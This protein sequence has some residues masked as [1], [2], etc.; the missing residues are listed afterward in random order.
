MSETVG[1]KTFLSKS[2]GIGGAIKEK[3]EDFL[4]E[5]ITPE[6]IVLEL[7]KNQKFENEEGEYTHFTLEKTNWDTIR[8]VKNVAKRCGV[9][10]KRLKYAGTKDRRSI[11]AQRVS[12]WKVPAEKLEKINI[13]DIALRDFSTAKDPIN[14]GTL[15]GN[16]FSILIKK[17]PDDADNRLEKIVSELKNRAPNFFGTQR[18]G[19][20]MNNHIIGKHILR[21]EFEEAVMAYLCDTGNEPDEATKE[22]EKLREGKDF[23]RAFKH[24]PDYLGYEK[25]ILNRLMKEPTDF[26]GSLRELPKKLRWMFV[27]AYQ[28]YIFNLALCDY[29]ESGEIPEEIPL[30]GTETPPDKVSDKILKREKNSQKDFTVPSM[31]EM[32]STGNMRKSVISFKDF[33]I[34][35]FNREKHKIW[36]RFGLPPGAY[37]TIVLRELMK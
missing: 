17:V 37:A 28:G 19:S 26:I 8:A 29:I 13:K 5:E 24:F 2:E 1:L 16:R 9:S 33:E 25:A 14:L 3:P 10:H 20:R 23:S 31:P 6:G 32:T 36:V 21:G 15:K 35:D 27:H 11:S 12:I 18:F 4:V 7:G 22:R 30:V 34:L